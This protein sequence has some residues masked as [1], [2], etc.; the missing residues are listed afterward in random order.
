M[1]EPV[2]GD[3]DSA[4][5]GHGR[6]EVQLGHG[7]RDPT[8]RP[9]RH[10]IEVGATGVEGVVPTSGQFGIERYRL[11]ETSVAWKPT[12]QLGRAASFSGLAGLARDDYHLHVGGSVTSGA[13][14]SAFDTVDENVQGALLGV[15]V[16]AGWPL[17]GVFARATQMTGIRTISRIADVGIELH[18]HER[19]DLQ[20]AY[21]WWRLRAEDVSG[22]TFVYSDVDLDVEGLTIGG[23]LRF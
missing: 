19:V 1:S 7:R 5:F 10:A 11:L 6:I 23:V 17:V 8:S 15:E 18:V 22:D 13:I 12:L 20:V 21:R 14:S 2:R 9:F 4:T 16:R 3:D